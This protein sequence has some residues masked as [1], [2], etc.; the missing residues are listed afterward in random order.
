M[1]PKIM[2]IMPDANG[3][4]KCLIVSG[5]FSTG[6]KLSASG[7]NGVLQLPYRIRVYLHSLYGSCDIS[8]IR[9]FLQ[10]YASSI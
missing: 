10:N 6:F 4:I 1:I 8:Q 7:C 9:T 3:N 5:F 2:I